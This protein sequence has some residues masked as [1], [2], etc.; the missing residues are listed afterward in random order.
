MNLFKF[1]TQPCLRLADEI[2]DSAK[3]ISICIDGKWVVSRS[4]PF[5]YYFPM[6]IINRFKLAYGVF[7]GKYDAVRFIGQ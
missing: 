7:S 3:T 5:W 6:S 2:V 1:N 4:E